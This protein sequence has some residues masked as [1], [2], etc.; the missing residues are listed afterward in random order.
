M[1]VLGV[2]P[3]LRVTGYGV[4]SFESRG[5]DLVEAGVIRTREAEG[6]GVR[7]HRIYSG[8]SDVISEHRPDVLVIEKIFTHVEFPSTAILMGHARGVVCLLSGT[9]GV[10]LVS[11]ASTHV[12]KSL[13]GRGHA[14]KQQMQR[15]IQHELGLKEMPE[16]ADVADAIAIA[17][18]YGAGAGRAFAGRARVAR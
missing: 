4:L 1:R 13:T 11:M 5:A 2:D 9:H 8:L 12:K 17:F 15:M 6:I 3:G 7:L 18:S 10:P 14:S 16:P